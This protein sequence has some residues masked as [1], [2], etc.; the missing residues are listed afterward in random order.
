MKTSFHTCLQRKTRGA[1][2]HKDEHAH[3]GA[4]AESSRSCLRPRPPADSLAVGLD[5]SSLGV[6]PRVEEKVSQANLETPVRRQQVLLGH[7]A[8]HPEV[9]AE[10]VAAVAAVDPMRRCDRRAKIRPAALSTGRKTWR[11][12][13]SAST[14]TPCLRCRPSRRRRPQKCRPAATPA[15]QRRQAA[16]CPG[17]SCKKKGGAEM[18]ARRADG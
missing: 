18:W 6:V 8:A 11:R 9:A 15:S 4:S 2:R 1:P 7:K 14:R 5:D 13:A 3:W 17:Q 12:S 16:H 10:E